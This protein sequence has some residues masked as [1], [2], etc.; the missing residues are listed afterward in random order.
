MNEELNRTLKWAEKGIEYEIY[1]IN[2]QIEEI[3]KKENYHGKVE[4]I[5]Q[6]KI[7]KEWLSDELDSIIKSGG[8]NE[9]Y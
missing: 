3:E 1:F 5:K 4:M 6:L 7:H 9:V 8:Q 2:K